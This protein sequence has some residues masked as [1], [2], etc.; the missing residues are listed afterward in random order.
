[1]KW[2]FNHKKIKKKLLLAEVVLLIASV[3]VFRGL[4]T[5][6]DS[7]D[8]MWSTLALVLSLVLGVLFSIIAL[9]YIIQND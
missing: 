1:M 2:E 7:F 3:F 5:I 6:L 8:F 4:W 9:R